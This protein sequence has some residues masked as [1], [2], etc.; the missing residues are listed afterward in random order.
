MSIIELVDRRWRT[1]LAVT[2]RGSG[3]RRAAAGVARTFA[4]VVEQVETAASR[5]REDSEISAV[6]AMAGRWV[7]VSPLLG[8]LVEV[9]VAAAD[10]TDGIVSPCLGA[11]VDAAGYRSWA[12]GEVAI[13][14]VEDLV[15]QPHAWRDVEIRDG[16]VRIPPGCQLDLGATAKAWLADEVA[17]E[18]WRSTGLDVVASMG[19]DLRAI[20]RREPWVVAADHAGG[21]DPWAVELVDAGMATSGQGRRRWRT[22]SGPAHHIIDPRTGRS[23][24]SRWWSVTV[25]AASATAAN[26]ASTAAVVLDGQAAAWLRAHRLDAWLSEPAGGRSEVLGRWPQR[27]G[28]A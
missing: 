6:N 17:E 18:V 5:F 26:I 23:A 15:A 2:L 11:H 10:R 16:C 9:A 7:A 27:M 25:I 22:A 8:E 19:G 24:V 12:A 3:A 21:H 13:P 20:G 4:G 1:T 28:A 14:D